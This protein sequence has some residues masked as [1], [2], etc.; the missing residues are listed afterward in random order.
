M[1]L[2]LTP[3]V[4]GGNPKRKRR[5]NPPKSLF[6]YNSAKPVNHALMAHLATLESTIYRRRKA[7]IWAA[8]YKI[9]PSIFLTSKNNTS[10]VTNRANNTGRN[11]PHEIV[12]FD[13][14]GTI[15]TKD[16]FALFLRYYAG[17]AQWALNITALLPT[18]ISYKLGI[19]DRHAVKRAVVKRFFKGHDAQAVDARAA[20]FAKD[21]IPALI[22]PAAQAR[23]D[24]LKTT[25]EFGQKFG[26]ESLYI[27]SASIGPYLRHWAKTQNISENRV[28]A[29]EL[30]SK[31]GA[32]T[33]ALNGYNV[34]GANKVRRIYDAFSPHSVSILEAYGDTRGDKEMLHA[35]KASF[36]KPFR[37]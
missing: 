5:I 30:E 34:W 35:A 6:I 9:K 27:C 13:F 26:P 36:Y 23:L 1:S 32:L 8:G 19:I 20:Q 21:V 31:G 12:V 10:N 7:S 16:T 14:D 24:A 18:F 25:T 15:T 33:G 11:A 2:T 22:R 3:K 29:T 37:F 17:T 28:L 4:D